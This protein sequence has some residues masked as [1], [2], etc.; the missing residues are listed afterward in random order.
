MEASTRPNILLLTVDQLMFPR[1]AY[2]PY[3]GFHPGIKDILGFIDAGGDD[4]PFRKFFPGFA[5]LR[6]NAAI[7]RNHTIAASACIPSR[8]AIYTGQ[9]GTRT[10]VTQTDGLFKSG[11][12]AAFPWLAADGIPTIGHWFQKAGYHTHY[13]GKWHVSNPPEHSL[14]RYGF[15]DW[16]LSYP[17]PHGSS[18]NNLGAFRDIGF[19]DLACD[20]LRRMALGQPYNRALAEQAYVAPRADPPSTTP[21][22]WLAVASFTNPHDIATYP[23]LPR[24]LDPNALPVGPLHVPTEG[25]RSTTPVSGSLTFPLNPLN[26]PQDNARLPANVHD[27]LVNK[28]RCQRDYAYKMGLAL[29]AKT[30]LALHQ[31]KEEIDP[32]TVTL[33]SGIPFQLTAAPDVSTLRFNQYYAWLI[34][35]VDGHIARVLR[36]LD[37]SGLRENTLVVF[38]SDHGEY[39]GAH[40]YMMEKWHTAYQEALHVPLVVQFPP[41][42]QLPPATRRIDALTSHVDILPTL[43]GLANIPPAEIAAI[44]TD[45][46]L[47]R[48]VPPFVGADLSPLA[49]GDSTTVV[50]PDG[51]PREGVLFVTDDEITEPLPRTGDPHQLHDEALFSV[52]VRSVEALREGTPHAGK[53]PELAPGAVCQPNHVRCMR[54]PRWKL[55][56]TW[57]PSGGHAD[58][59]ELYDLENDPLEMEN[60]LVYDGPFPTVI[61]DLPEKLTHAQVEAAARATH[62]LLE[63]Y[64]AKVLSPWPEEPPAAP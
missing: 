22:P 60:L 6:Q 56:R 34:H 52:F 59:W 55:A 20:F 49:R 11:D 1:F 54:T 37:E 8:A 15:D 53:V 27:T 35:L 45:L 19:A 62:A 17:E 10:G 31:A 57:D 23:I 24:Q 16:E 3:G 9:Y 43:L 32:V 4:N 64:E 25:T 47:H 41:Q 18:V 48:P 14:K 61:A 7:F 44:R 30:G 46:R 26:F 36:T 29:A 51:T 13:F 40:G 38:L 50:E 58:Q 33:N 39:A 63:K 28:P 21:Q 12:A 2:G 5:A 42:Q